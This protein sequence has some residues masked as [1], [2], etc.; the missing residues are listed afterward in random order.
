M[1]V[2]QYIV[3]LVCKHGDIYILYD[4]VSSTSFQ[5]LTSH[6][7]SLTLVLCLEE[8][9]HSYPVLNVLDVCNQQYQGEDCK[10]S[11]LWENI[12]HII[13][14]NHLAPATIMCLEMEG[15]LLCFAIPT[16]Y[17]LYQKFLLDAFNLDWTNLIFRTRVLITY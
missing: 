7:Q 14:I 17:I 13:V 12:N 5:I 1:T 9:T 6:G 11:I 15:A 8:S 4:L 16:T 3:S 2:C 10:I